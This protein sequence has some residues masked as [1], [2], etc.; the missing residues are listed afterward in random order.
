MVVIE[1]AL[2]G[3]CLAVGVWSAVGSV[4]ALSAEEPGPDRRVLVLHEWAKAGFWL[5][6]GAFLLGYLVLDDPREIRG[7]AL[8][9]IVLAG[10]RFLAAVRLA[11]R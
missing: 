3:L 8:V 7:F 1:I 5:T 10:I 2:G 6:L 9:P 4:R 11:R